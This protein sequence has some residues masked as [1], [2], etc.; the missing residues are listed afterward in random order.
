MHGS[1]PDA[2]K[3]KAVLGFFD[4]SLNSGQKLAEDLI[5]VPLPEKL[6]KQIE[7]TWTAGIKDSAG[8]PV[9]P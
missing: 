4:W 5:Y 9:Y 1:Q 2:A 3:A 7:A 8:K 6:V